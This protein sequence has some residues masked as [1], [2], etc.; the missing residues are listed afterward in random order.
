MG[1]VCCAELLSHVQ[2]FATLQTVA[3]QAP[4]FMRILQARILEWVAYPFPRG[5]F[6]TQG[7][8]Q[9]VLALQADS[10]L[11]ELPEKPIVMGTVGYKDG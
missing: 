9:V 11:A 8:N 10:L 7:Q 4:L 3:C 1:A 2:V 6:P 5:I